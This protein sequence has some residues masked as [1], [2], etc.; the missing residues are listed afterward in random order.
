MVACLIVT[1]VGLWLHG[2][3]ASGVFERELDEVAALRAQPAGER[4]WV[5]GQVAWIEIE[6][7]NINYPVMQS[8]NNTWYLNHDYLGRDDAMGAIFLDY[9]NDSDFRDNVSI[10]YGHRTSG[11]L[12]FSDVA[13]YSDSEFFALHLNGRLFLRDGRVLNLSAYKYMLLSGEDSLYRD[14]RYEDSGVIVLSTCSREMRGSRD[15]LVM[16]VESLA[17]V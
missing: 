8:S 16:R 5:A 17:D 9:R 12:M 14:L 4:N 7:T 2:S 10:L 13:K 3:V 15:V 6:G 1:G 11:K